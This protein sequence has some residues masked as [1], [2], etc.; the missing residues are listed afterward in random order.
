[1]KK[2]LFSVAT[3]FATNF[4][5]GQI[6]LEHSFNISEN[7]TAYSKDETVYVSFVRNDNKFKIYNSDYS[8]RKIVN[9][10]MPANY[11]SI[12]IGDVNGY[13]ISKYIFNTDD[14]FEFLVTISSSVNGNRDKLL[15][16]NEDGI[17]IKD[18]NPNSQTVGYRGYSEIFHDVSTNKNKFLVNN[19]GTDDQFDLYSLPTTDLGSKEINKKNLLSAFPIPTSKILNVVNPQNGANKIEVFD[20]S[21]KLIINKGFGN[22]ESK[23]SIDV[24]NLPKGVYIYRVGDLSAK[25]LKN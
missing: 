23:I 13:H 21:G 25:F 3:I 17:L 20:T 19:L 16:I 11:D 5:F 12:W 9:I 8:L 7:I 2:V 22:S 15:L 18:F 24:E 14:K 1:M 6:T 4:T 10:S